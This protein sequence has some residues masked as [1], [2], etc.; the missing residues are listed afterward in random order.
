[1]KESELD[2]IRNK[3][4]FTSCDL[5]RAMLLKLIHSYLQKIV[6]IQ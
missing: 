2:G 4:I 1:M 3:L 5:N 6:T